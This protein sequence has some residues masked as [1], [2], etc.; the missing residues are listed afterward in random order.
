MTCDTVPKGMDTPAKGAGFRLRYSFFLIVANRT[1]QMPD[2]PTPASSMHIAVLEDDA[3]LR[4][5]IL[6]PGLRDFGFDVTGAGTAAEL[7]RHMLRQ[8]FDM[9]VLDIGLPD[10]D[11]LTVAKHLRELSDLGIVMLTGN[12]GKQDHLRALTLGADAYLSKPVDVDVLAATLHSLARRLKAPGG[13]SAPNAA[14]EQATGQAA[15]QQWHLDT[16]GWCLV[17]PNGTVLALTAPER[18]LLHTLI[19]AAGQPV[20]REALIAALCKDVYD[21][22]PHRLEMLVHR[23]RRKA[24]DAEAGVLP[25][26]TSRGNGYLFV[27]QTS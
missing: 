5:A 21:F 17:A 9:V 15:K 1:T 6:L 22:D 11:G 3:E 14:A 4:E 10:E 19:A 24:T 2:R 23:L 16:D 7:Y 26:L 20:P 18:R 12:R 8:R 27:A 25:L 13:A